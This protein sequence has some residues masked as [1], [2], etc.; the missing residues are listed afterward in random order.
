MQKEARIMSK[1]HEL[2]I[3]PEFFDKVITGSMNFDLRRDDGGF[4][5]GDRLLLREHNGRGYTG[6]SV[7]VLITYILRDFEGLKEGYSILGF[8][9]EKVKI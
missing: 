6:C 8:K 5:T 9:L 7:R 3:R 4:E 2:K 1:V